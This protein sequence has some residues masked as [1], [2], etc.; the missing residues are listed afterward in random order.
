[1]KASL[2]LFN[3]LQRIDFGGLR[4]EGRQ[5]KKTISTSTGPTGIS[6][7]NISGLAPKPPPTGG[8]VQ[9]A[10]TGPARSGSSATRTSFRS[11]GP[12]E[13]FSFST[14]GFENFGNNPRWGLASALSKVSKENPF[15]FSDPKEQFS[16]KEGG[17]IN[18]K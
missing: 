18:K 15:G 12:A 6:D 4:G 2:N 1:M 11:S 3:V 16:F 9:V 10:A 14:K 8:R 13:G 7:V 17:F 5:L